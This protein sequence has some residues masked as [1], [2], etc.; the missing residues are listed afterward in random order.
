MGNNL[1][2]DTGSNIFGGKDA[3]HYRRENLC[4]HMFLLSQPECGSGL[5][6]TDRPSN[7]M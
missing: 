1:H 6:E 7:F 2:G 4:R 5:E 3:F